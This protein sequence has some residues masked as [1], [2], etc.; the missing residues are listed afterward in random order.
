MKSALL[1]L[2]VDPRDRAALTPYVELVEGS[3]IETGSLV[4]PIA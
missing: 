3:N 4:A 2:L 1:N